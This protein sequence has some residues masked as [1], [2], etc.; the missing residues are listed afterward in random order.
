MNIIIVG[1]RR[2]G[3]TI[4][5]DCLY[6]DKRFDSYY[7]PFTGNKNDSG[8]GSGVRKISYQNKLRNIRQAFLNVN[9]IDNDLS[10][11]NY[12]PSRDFRLELLKNIP[13][14]H[15]NYLKYIVSQNKNT[16]L[17]FVRLY[18]K[19]ETLHQFIPNAKIIHILKDPRRMTMSHLLGSEK[20]KNEGRIKKTI[21]YFINKKKRFFFFKQKSKFDKWAFEKIINEIINKKLK[22][23]KYK[24]SYSYEKLMLLWKIYNDNLEYEGKK[25]Y[26]NN[27]LR[28]K[29]EELCIY[30]K[31]VLNKIYS[32]V[33]LSPNE[34]VIKWAIKNIRTP[35]KIFRVKSNHWQNS[36][37]KIGINFAEWN[38]YIN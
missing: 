36:E 5:Y 30:P 3:T 27:Y 34:S 16:L 19:I 37:E 20:L 11:F 35:K 6:N 23:K 15:R 4:L 9:N 13:E 32:F 22:Y 2:S 10:I 14:L 12:G 26:K 29:H 31:K 7:E 18:N 21:K 1:M 17:K 25:Y 28:I 38:K 24:N 8:G 33:E